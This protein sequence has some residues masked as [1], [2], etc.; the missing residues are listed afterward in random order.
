MKK[1]D[2]NQIRWIIVYQNYEGL[3][4]RAVELLF[5]AVKTHLDHIPELRTADTV[6]TEELATCNAFVIGTEQGNALVQKMVGLGATSA[7]QEKEGYAITVC[8]SPFAEDRKVVTIVGGGDAGTLYGVVDFLSGYMG[9]EAHENNEEWCENRFDNPL[10]KDMPDFTRVSAPATRDRGIWTW[11]HVISDYNGFFRNMAMLK[12]NTVVIWN[13]FA[14]LNAKE[15]IAAAHSWGVKILFGY[16]WGWLLHCNEADL[17]P[18][19]LK[20]LSDHCVDV[21]R[22]EYM[23]LGAD[24]IYFQSFTELNA[25]YIGDK[26]IA[27]VVT[28][29]VNDTAQKLFDL[30]PDLRIQF[31]LHATSVKNRLGQLA[32]VDK[33]VE[34][35]WENCGAFPFHTWAHVEEGQEDMLALVEKTATLRGKDDYYGVVLK[36]IHQL[37]WTLFEHQKA[38]FPIGADSEKFLQKRL[39]R[40]RPL[41]KFSQAYWLK[42]HELAHRCIRLM[43]TIRGKELTVEMLVEDSQFERA[44]RLPVALCA[45]MLWDGNTPSSE[46]L[47]RVALNPYVEFANL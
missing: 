25:E 31:G 45:E 47:E 14:P 29:F 1:F 37:D 42:N 41:W 10:N 12:L 38:T 2:P 15:I 13:D 39:N 3:Q 35:V 44:I 7:P 8:K 28:E 21:Y 20:A 18:K 22:K 27:E 34:I 11:G 17:S 4:K 30:Q 36:G 46:I 6:T 24:G 32:G 23:P 33:R 16:A 9:K 40:K 19:G 43:N 5:G 26:L